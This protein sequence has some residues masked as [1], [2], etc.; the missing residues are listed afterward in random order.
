MIA[1]APTSK[2]GIHNGKQNGRP[3]K[4]LTTLLY[5]SYTSNEGLYQR[6]L[7]EEL[8]ASI[9]YGFSSFIIT[10]IYLL[11][12]LVAATI[13][14]LAAY[15]GHRVAVTVLGAINTVLAG[16]TA[17]VKGMG[18]PN[19]L[20]KSRDQFHHIREYAEYKERQFSKYDKLGGL[21]TEPGISALDPWIEAEVVRKMYNAAKKDQQDNYPDLYINNNEREQMQSMSLADRGGVGSQFKVGQA[22]FSVPAGQ[23]RAQ[24]EVDEHH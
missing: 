12:I 3:R 22:G 20:R 24:V 2:D 6:A 18:L 5:N 23:A 15:E 17:Y 10:T 11:Q 9:G 14:A 7:N 13:T 4:K 16:L 8:K 1:T 21:K 19:R